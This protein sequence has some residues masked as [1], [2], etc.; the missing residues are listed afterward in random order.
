MSSLLLPF[1]PFLKSAQVERINVDIKNTATREWNMG[2]ITSRQ[3]R[4]RRRFK[5]GTQI[6]SEISHRQVANLIRLRT[7]Q[8]H[9]NSYLHR[10]KIIDHS[11]SDCK[12]GVET[13]KHFLLECKE[14]VTP[15]KQLREK[16]GARNMKMGT[17]LGDPKFIK[18][19]L[20]FV[21]ETG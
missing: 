2:K 5:T 18:E 16:V 10:H 3:L 14:Y 6:K 19:T 21:D 9:L 13:P 17:L 7:G 20:A 15:R 4:Q 12:K 8:C 11:Q 1:L